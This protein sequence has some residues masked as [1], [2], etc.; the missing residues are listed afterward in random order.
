MRGLVWTFV[1]L[2]ALAA[3]AHAEERRTVV[4]LSGGLSAIGPLDPPDDAV[5]GPEETGLQ[6]RGVVSFEDAPVPYPAPKHTRFRGA[7]VPELFVAAI[8]TD[9]TGTELAGGGFRLQLDYALGGVPDKPG[10]RWR[11]AFYVLGH[12]GLFTDRDTT[13]FLETGFGEYI[14]LGARTRLGCEL[15][16][17]SLRTRG[18]TDTPQP[19]PVDGALAGPPFQQG[20]GSYLA[21]NG[22]FY[23]G[24]SL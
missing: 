10:L 14:L 20:R 12:A 11:G 8:R 24:V 19:L 3:V 7:L 16:V 18:A 4:T 23:L 5:A 6:L 1:A 15:T 17:A 9:D 22:A 21:I 13:V 2:G